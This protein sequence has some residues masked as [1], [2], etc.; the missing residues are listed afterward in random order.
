[1]A[2]Q[3]R[4]QQGSSEAPPLEDPMG[5]ANTVEV[6]MGGT[7]ALEDPMGGANTVTHDLQVGATGLGTSSSIMGAGPQ[8]M[9]QVVSGNQT[10]AL[11]APMVQ[12]A[13]ESLTHTHTPII[14]N[15]YTQKAQL[16]FDAKA[17]C[18]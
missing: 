13:G 7:S 10:V 8:A 3:L 5:G 18:V 4:Q 16:H 11:E 12:D 6:P 2:Q 9:L 17:L 14:I 15:L 1:M